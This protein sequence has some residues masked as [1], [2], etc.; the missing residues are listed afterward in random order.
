MI[1]IIEAI[2]LKKILQ[3]TLK[4]KKEEAWCKNIYKGSKKF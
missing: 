2:V 1:P 3:L 4:K